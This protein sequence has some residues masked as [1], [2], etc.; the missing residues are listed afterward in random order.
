LNIS[1]KKLFQRG[2]TFSFSWKSKPIRR[3]PFKALLR[4]LVRLSWGQ[5]INAD[6]GSNVAYC[7]PM[8]VI[9]AYTAV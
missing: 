7:I 9:L 1:K 2:H 8:P 6:L 3:N 4:A 5:L